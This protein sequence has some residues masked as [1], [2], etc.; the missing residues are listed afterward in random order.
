MSSRNVRLDA[1]ARQHARLLN[2]A[3]LAAEAS[4]AAGERRADPVL[5]AARDV[6]AR[7]SINPEYLALVATDTL[8]PVDEI[9]GEA[10]LAVAAVVGGVRLI[11]NTL[12]ST[13][14]GRRTT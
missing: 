13:N 7:E 11:D 10:L 4:V 12:L 5:K 2:A 8:K 14:P 1:A 9:R 3:L 6:L